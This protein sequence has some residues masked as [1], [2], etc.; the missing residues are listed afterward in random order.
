MPEDPG[1]QYVI[2]TLL[3]NRTVPS[4]PVVR[5]DAGDDTAVLQDGTLVT[6]D[7]LVEGVHWDHRAAPGDVG[8]KAVAV[9]VSDIA[10]MGGRPTW[11][12]L[13]LSMPRPLNRSWIEGFSKGFQAACARWGVLLV[14]GDTTRS[15]G[16]TV[17]TVTLAGAAPSP[18]LRSGAQ[19]GD[20]IWVTGVPGEAAAG[21]AMGGEGLR[22]LHHPEPPLELALALAEAGLLHAAMDLSDG[23]ATDLPRLCRA[24]GVGATV[25]PSRLPS[26]AITEALAQPLEAMVAFGDDYQLLFTAAPRHRDAIGAL[27]RQHH[28]RVSRIGSIRAEEGAVLVGTSWPE[29]AFAHFAPVSGEAQS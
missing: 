16:P 21:F 17:V 18:V 13:A 14:G 11:A 10:A 26:S 4:S 24:S 9:N 2:E 7:T 28:T 22:A 6:T 1:E 3:R 29:P 20:D 5:V 23:L 19:P 12:T 8:W 27:A 25:Q 15:P